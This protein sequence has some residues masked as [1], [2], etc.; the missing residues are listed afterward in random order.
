MCYCE[1][2]IFYFVILDKLVLFSFNQKY[3]FYGE[4]I[5]YVEFLYAHFYACIKFFHHNH[6]SGYFLVYLVYQHQTKT[7]L[8][9]IVS[10]SQCL[11]N[12]LFLCHPSWIFHVISITQCDQQPQRVRKKLSMT[13]KVQL[14]RYLKILLNVQLIVATG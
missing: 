4:K 11:T 13:T 10:T 14:I 5:Q 12:V 7:G 3:L 6:L 2:I 9:F 8:E 1:K